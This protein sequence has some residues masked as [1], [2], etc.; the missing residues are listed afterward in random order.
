M[1]A[2]QHTKAKSEKRKRMHVKG[3]RMD[4]QE[5]A[6]FLQNS[7]EAGLSPGDYFRKQCCGTRTRRRKK[8]QSEIDA[9]V[10]IA[11]MAQLGKWGSNLNQIAKAINKAMKQDQIGTV[12]SILAGKSED[13]EALGVVVSECYQTISSTLSHVPQRQHD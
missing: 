5:L 8:I 10:F 7:Q 13:I 11:I 4:D 3:L 1:A 9:S 12:S 6:T 2:K